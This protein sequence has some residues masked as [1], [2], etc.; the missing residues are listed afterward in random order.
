MIH[1]QEIIIIKSHLEIT[2]I[3]QGYPI[4]LFHGW[5]FDH[6]VWQVLVP[7]LAPHYALYLVDL[8]GFGH[9]DLLDWDDFKQQLLDQ[10]PRQFA[11]SGWSLGGLYA[12][13]LACEAP[14]RVTHLI[15][16]ASSPC[17]VQTGDW[18]GIAQQVFE[19]FH[20]KLAQNPQQTILN[21]LALQAPGKVALPSAA[22]NYSMDGLIKGLDILLQWD[23]RNHLHGYPHAG[24][25]IFGRLDAIIPVATLTAMRA[26]Y[27]QFSYH[28]IRQAGHVPFLSHR[29]AFIALVKDFMC[30]N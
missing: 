29:E 25:F 4:V 28:L 11:V 30:N 2:T 23:L 1:N 5:G 8:P 10:L 19:D 24:C 16:V 14:E 15:S 18:P 21:F 12:M 26:V 27:P 9:S 20:A 6:T 13:R 7:E 17:C 3:G 22:S